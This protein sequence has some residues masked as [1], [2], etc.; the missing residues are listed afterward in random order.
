M[1]IISKISKLEVALIYQRTQFHCFFFYF[2]CKFL[3]FIVFICQTNNIHVT[4][5]PPIFFKF[6]KN[7]STFVPS[8]RFVRHMMLHTSSC[9]IIVQKSAIV[10]GLGPMKKNINDQIRQNDER[11]ETCLIVN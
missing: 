2:M 3:F 1:T 10:F 8:V 6:Q 4:P 5:P 11:M 9:Q 7:T